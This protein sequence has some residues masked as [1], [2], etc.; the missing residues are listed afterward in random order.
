[1]N[2][3][4]DTGGYGKES[5]LGNGNNKGK[6]FKGITVAAKRLL[7]MFSISVWVSI[8]FSGPGMCDTLASSFDVIF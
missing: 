8:L 4:D 1:M 3:L 5:Y 7:L 2:L 6:P